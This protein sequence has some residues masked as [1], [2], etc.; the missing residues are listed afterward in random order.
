MITD[1]ERALINRA[2]DIER[3]RV[4]VTALAIEARVANLLPAPW[5]ELIAYNEENEVLVEVCFQTGID[6]NEVDTWTD[7]ECRDFCEWI[8]HLAEATRMHTSTEHDGEY[9]DDES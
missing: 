6:H 1:D 9:D 7:R 4:E 3:Q 5:A 8:A 2:K